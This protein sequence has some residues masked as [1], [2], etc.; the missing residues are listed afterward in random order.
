MALESLLKLEKI[1]KSVKNMGNEEII[2]S[3]SSHEKL[4][5]MLHNKFSFDVADQAL[6]LV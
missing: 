2:K 4:L 5:E 3:F 1:V 6:K